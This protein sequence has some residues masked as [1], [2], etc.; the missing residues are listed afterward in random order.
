MNDIIS[1]INRMPLPTEPMDDLI[2]LAQ[3]GDK[4]AT[5][6]VLRAHM[7]ILVNEITRAVRIVT[8]GGFV[9]SSAH[10]R[11]D[12][13][14]DALQVFFRALEAY[15]PERSKTGRF[16]SLL[17]TALRRDEAL[18]SA[19]NRVRAFRVP[20]QMAMR[21]AAAIKA[22]GGDMEKARTLAP[23]F[24]ITKSTFDAISDLYDAGVSMNNDDA[25]E[26]LF[27]HS[28]SGYVRIDHLQ[29]VARA[30]EGLDFTTRMI[31]E[32]SY[33]LNGQPQQ[34]NV[35]IAAALGISRRSVARRL[36]AAMTTMQATLQK[37][38][39]Q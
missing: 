8:Q 31:V 21:R 34:S 1:T 35:E 32:S 12:V 14:S 19:I 22:A 23:Q 10:L 7:G 4:D 26:S 20:V 9:G 15:D 11:D 24:N 2:A 39:E 6:K 30:L 25:P 27:G 28:E 33:G 16:G 38:Q 13:T 37:E 17:T 18:N 5:L 36:D 3:I 29:D